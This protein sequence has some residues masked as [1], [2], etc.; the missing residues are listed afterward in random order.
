[1]LRRRPDK[2]TVPAFEVASVKP[3]PPVGPSWTM[4]ADGG[5]GPPTISSSFRETKEMPGYAPIAGKD[6][7]RLKAHVE[8]PAA[9]AAASDLRD[10]LQKPGNRP[11]LLPINRGGQTVFIPAP[12]G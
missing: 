11:P 9:G 3:S 10:A 1:M 2:T 5:L 7:P 6:G 12:L 4:R 8:T